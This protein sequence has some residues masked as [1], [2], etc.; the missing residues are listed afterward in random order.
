[1]RSEKGIFYG[2][3]QKYACLNWCYHLHEYL[4][5]AGGYALEPSLED[6]LIRRLKD[7][8]THSL[9]FWVNTV[10]AGGYGKQLD[11]LDLCY[12][13]WGSVISRLVSKFQKSLTNFSLAIT[14]SLTRFS[15]VINRYEEE[16]G[17][18]SCLHVCKACS[19][20]VLALCVVIVYRYYKFWLPH[21]GWQDVSCLLMVLKPRA[22]CL[23]IFIFRL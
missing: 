9:D 15:S 19:N 8:A 4:I 17:G 21:R 22:H 18:G 7:V 5:S 20:H 14:T 23:W 12:R 2:G 16:C 10:L 1:M 11:V 13:C 6:A 3:V